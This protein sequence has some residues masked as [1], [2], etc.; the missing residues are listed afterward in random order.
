MDLF[1]HDFLIALTC[2]MSAPV[3]GQQYL[4][5]LNWCA[6]N[7][8]ARRITEEVYLP[9]RPPAEVLPRLF[10]ASTESAGIKQSDVEEAEDFRGIYQS[11]NKFVYEQIILNNSSFCL[12][13]VGDDLIRRHLVAECQ[14]C[15]LKPAH[16]FLKYFDIK[17][18]FE[19]CYPEANVGGS[20]STMLKCRR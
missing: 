1:D 15:G 3:D 2:S 18:E 19:R 20:L 9:V 14:R 11:F 4:L 8:R 7:V 17:A 10:P 12:V 6:Y 13:S 5:E 16:H